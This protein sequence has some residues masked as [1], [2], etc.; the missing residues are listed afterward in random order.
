MAA[1][2]GAV[3]GGKKPGWLWP[4]VASAVSFAV[5]TGTPQLLAVLDR[6]DKLQDHA[7]NLT[8]S[9]RDYVLKVI[10]LQ[11]KA[12]PAQA[13]AIAA[14]T[15]SATTTY[16]RDPKFRAAFADAVTVYALTISGA[17]AA[18]KSAEQAS[19]GEAPVSA[20]A[21]AALGQVQAAAAITSATAQG[22][23]PAAAQAALSA[24]KGRVFFQVAGPDD[25]GAAETVNHQLT[26]TFK[27]QLTPIEGI[28][29]IPAF[30]GET[31][32]R[33]FFA[34]DKDE[35]QTLAGA[36]AG[37]FPD[38]SCRFIGGYGSS[39]KVKPQLFEVWL[40][41]GQKPAGPVGQGGRTVRC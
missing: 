24:P 30:K 13:Q 35:A 41:P 19:K 23:A 34:D 15:N 20:G 27:D 31:Q 16:L 39:G 1:V 7:E 38:L 8:D 29:V 21:S 10:E 22:A 36:L 18:A 26:A 32:L 3:A 5:G 6:Q 40:S 14:L 37:A 33:Y 4:A 28:Q 11:S 12:S 2:K 9:E 25:R 17:D